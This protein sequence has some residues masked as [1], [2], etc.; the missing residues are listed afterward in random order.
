MP[1]TLV[2]PLDENS[3]AQVAA[4]RR[5]DSLAGKTVALLDISKPGGNLFLDSLEGLLKDRHGV[6]QVVRV[7]KPTFT[8]P[9][10][11]DIIERLAGGPVHAVVEAL[12][13]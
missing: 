1:I 3:R 5:L 2:N 12:A 6:A 13:D 7:H 4:A 9:A 10:P 8:R 11:D